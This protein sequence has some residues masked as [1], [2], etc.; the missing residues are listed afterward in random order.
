M[1]GREKNKSDNKR[2]KKDRYSSDSDSSKSI[3]EEKRSNY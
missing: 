1:V 2:H 3:K